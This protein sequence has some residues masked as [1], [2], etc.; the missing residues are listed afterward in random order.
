MIANHRDGRNVKR[1]ERATRLSAATSTSNSPE[2]STEWK[3]DGEV[4]IEGANNAKNNPKD[5]KKENHTSVK[6]LK[7]VPCY[8]PSYIRNVSFDCN[9]PKRPNWAN[10]TKRWSLATEKPSFQSKY[11]AASTNGSASLSSSSR[12]D[13]SRRTHRSLP[14]QSEMGELSFILR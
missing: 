5:S 10:Q 12:R 3:N 2:S 13:R 9:R 6:P 8:V 11:R 14:Q 7:T 4:F 1:R